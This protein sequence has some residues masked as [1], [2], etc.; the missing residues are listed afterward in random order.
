MECPVC[1]CN[2]TGSS[3]D[4]VPKV[5]PCGHT[6]CNTCV[7][8]LLQHRGWGRGT[9]SG[10]V[11]C[12]LCRVA[13][14]AS[15][16]T[17]NFA[18]C[19]ICDAQAGG[20]SHTSTS[21]AASAPGQMTMQQPLASQAL[22]QPLLGG[23]QPQ[24]QNATAPPA[25]Q[26]WDVGPQNMYAD[27]DAD[28]AASNNS[29]AHF[30]VPAGFDCASEA[31]WI[32]QRRSIL[33]SWG[34]KRERA[35][36]RQPQWLMDQMVSGSGLYPIRLLDKTWLTP[37]EQS[38][39]QQLE[40]LFE[41]TGHSH[42]L[43]YDMLTP[44]IYDI[45]LAII[46]DDSGSMS[47]DMFG[48]S[49]QYGGIDAVTQQRPGQLEYVLQQS[50]PGGWFT[51]ASTRQ[52][53]SPMP[54][55]ISPNQRRWFYARHHLRS[56]YRVFSILGLDPW[57]YTLNKGRYRCSEVEQVFEKGPS[58]STPMDVTFNSV[59]RDLAPNGSSR[60]KPLLILALTDGEANNMQ[61]FNTVLDQIQNLVHGD[62]QVCLMG[63]S[64]VKED[65]EWF[66]NEECDET[67]IRTVEA[68]E[69]ENRLMQ[70]KE[71]VKREGGYNFL[72]HT[73]R[74]LVTNY[75]PADYDYDA[76]LQNIRHR[77]YITIHGRDRWWGI[78]NPLWYMIG[79]SCLC[80]ACFLAT[81]C[82]CCGW[83]QG[84]DCGK[85]Q[86]PDVFAE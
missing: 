52:V 35:M 12:P 41:S 20:A 32:E 39:A 63:L 58:G 66:E 81:G 1:L 17:T 42:S 76:P 45:E 10:A 22:A 48:G 57:V 7:E 80:P 23:Q 27:N 30:T 67:R 50:L 64:L 78:N 16:V 15:E 65:I 79:S 11:A 34:W 53:R 72:M 55:P 19:N 13:A 4:R 3:G 25:I 28:G 75:Y 82:H 29:S 51:D 84:H 36:H 2:F 49:A 31:E 54:G 8:S 47:L 26:P 38:M 40:A 61:A 5:F 70:L 83:L 74:V 69:V 56:W 9:G 21:A 33:R 46:L 60:R 44:V 37:R 68:F 6:T 62:V 85:I 73:M 14:P 43:A 59:L 24:Q 86:W 77:L 18:L 71:V